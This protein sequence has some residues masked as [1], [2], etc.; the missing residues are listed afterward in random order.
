MGINI[1]AHYVTGLEDDGQGGK[2]RQT[3]EHQTFDFIRHAGDKDF[4]SSEEIDWVEVLDD[5]DSIDLGQRTYTRPK[6]IDSAIQ[7]LKSNNPNPDRLINL[8]EEMKKDSTLH[9]YVSY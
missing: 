3:I 5:P 6:D 8:L 2:Y 9:I 1:S 4:I 7:W